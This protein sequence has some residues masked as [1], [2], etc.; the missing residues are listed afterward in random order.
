MYSARYDT[1]DELIKQLTAETGIEVNIIE[2][3]STRLARMK[4]K[5]T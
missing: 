2:G 5:G 4:Q 3:K 1:D